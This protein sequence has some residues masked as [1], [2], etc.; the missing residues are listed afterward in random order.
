MKPLEYVKKYNLDK[1]VKFNHNSF[2]ADL[3]IDFQTLLQIGKGDQNLKGFENAVRAIRMKWDGI[4]NKTLGNLPDKLWNYF[5]ATVIVKLRNELFPSQMKARQQ[6]KE[7][8]RKRW[9][10]HKA[11]EEAESRM[12]NRFFY[13]SILNQLL[14]ELVSTTEK[15]KYLGVLNLD[16][17]ATIDDVK[18]SYRKLC[19]VYHPDKGGSNDKFIEITEAYNR[20][21]TYF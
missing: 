2:I 16:I 4:N 18:S 12:W 8:K 9:E 19:M 13:E 3:A 6:E 10:E 21:L 20:C 5:Y 11:F 7:E 14:Y 1:G 15:E 17:N